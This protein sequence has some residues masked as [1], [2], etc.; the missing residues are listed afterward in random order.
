M[1]AI[2]VIEEITFSADN[3]KEN[4]LTVYR[5]LLAQP[6]QITHRLDQVT[7]GLLVLSKRPAF[8]SYFNMLLERRHVEKTYYALVEEEVQES[9][10]K[11]RGIS[12]GRYSLWIQDSRRPP[13]VFFFFLFLSLFL[14]LSSSL[15]LITSIQQ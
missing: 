1:T 10:G 3:A 14:F 2:A 7:S 12:V 9:C 11:G 5:E 6:L 13:M 15:C 4:T 8:Q